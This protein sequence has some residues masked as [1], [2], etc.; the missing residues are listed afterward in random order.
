MVLKVLTPKDLKH[1]K[2]APVI[3]LDLSGRSSPSSTLPLSVHVR[4]VAP[5]GEHKVG[6]ELTN[7]AGQKRIHLSW[8]VL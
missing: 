1:P 2:L 8:H 4:H 6:G 7:C 5:H 3:A